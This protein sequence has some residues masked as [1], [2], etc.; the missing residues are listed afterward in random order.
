MLI[1]FLSGDIKI[2]QAEGTHYFGAG[3]IFLIPRHQPATIITHPKT[4]NA[5]KPWPCTSTAE[6]LQ[7]FYARNP[8]RSEQRGKPAKRAQFPQTPV[9]PESFLGSLIPY[10]DL[11]EAL[12]LDIASLKM[13]EAIRI[14]RAID[15]GIDDLLRR[16]SARQEKLTWA[17]FMEKNF[18]FNMSLEEFA[19]SSGTASGTYHRDFES[20]HYH[21]QNGLPKNAWSSP[22]T[23]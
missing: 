3:D 13:E 15:G 7:A 1:W 4:A 17:K 21:P 18:V 12:P 8:R 5:T 16:I 22:T 20:L 6:R 11:K 14:V 9:L 10:F 19:T 23:C 2:V